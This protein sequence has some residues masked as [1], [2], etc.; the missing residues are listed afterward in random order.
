MKMTRL[1]KLIVI[2]FLRLYKL[3]IS[4]YLR[5]ILGNGCRYDKSCSEFAI[6]AISEKGLVKGVKLSLKRFFSCQ[7]FSNRYYANLSDIK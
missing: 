1:I 6:E 7:P 2:L 3:V 4:N 5:T